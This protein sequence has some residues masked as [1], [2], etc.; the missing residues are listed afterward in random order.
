MTWSDLGSLVT[1]R[2][3]GAR[4]AR[5]VS[6]RRRDRVRSA[7]TEAL[8]TAIA[9]AAQGRPRDARGQSTRALE[10]LEQGRVSNPV[11]LAGA[12]RVH[13]RIEFVLGDHAEAARHYAKALAVLTADPAPQSERERIL[14]QAG[15]ANTLRVRGRY[16]EAVRLYSAAAGRAEQLDG[17]PLDLAAVLNGWGIVCKYMGEFDEA[18]RLYGRALRIVEAAVGVDHLD[19]AGIFHNLGGLAHARGDYVAAEPLARRAVELRRRVLHRNH[20]DVAADEAALA[21]ILDRLGKR[22]EAEK[23]LRRA[24]EIFEHVFG[25]CHCEVAITLNNLAAIVQHRREPAAAEDLY[26]RALAIKE[27]VLGPNH[28]EVATTLNN[29]ATALRA[30]Q[31]SAE[32][33]AVYRRSLAIL[34][35]TLGTDHPTTL[36]CRENYTVLLCSAASGK[37]R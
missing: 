8:A 28:P 19:A 14:N 16:T 27:R 4:P 2:G 30:Q 9:L 10:L 24:L 32:A 3:R 33:G 6:A 20:P 1:A 15:L 34:E 22:H 36:V 29:L 12:L 21:A 18:E 5:S 13:A 17:D 7:A 37:R 23:L 31:R 35:R 11:Q 25:P 26:R